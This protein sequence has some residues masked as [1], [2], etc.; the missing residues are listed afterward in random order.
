VKIV[1]LGYCRSLAARPHGWR[2]DERQWPIDFFSPEQAAQSVAI[3]ARTDVY[4]LGAVFYFLLTGQPPFP[5]GTTGQK[6]VWI[7]TRAPRAIR[8]LRPQILP[9]LAAIVMRMIK[10]DREKRFQTAQQVADGLAPWAAP[11]GPVPP[12]AEMPRHCKLV[13]ALLAG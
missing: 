7:Q 2:L 10:Q 9:E 5:D 8:E 1:D 4:S 13:Q 12:Q 6:L 11:V 3:D